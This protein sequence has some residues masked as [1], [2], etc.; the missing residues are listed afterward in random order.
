LGDSSSPLPSDD[1]SDR[2]TAGCGRTSCTERLMA[3]NPSTSTQGFPP[4]YIEDV[5]CKK[6]IAKLAPCTHPTGARRKRMQEIRP[7]ASSEPDDLQPLP[8]SGENLKRPSKRTG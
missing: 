6:V 7:A 1:K 5:T 2:V 8:H 4:H 3:R